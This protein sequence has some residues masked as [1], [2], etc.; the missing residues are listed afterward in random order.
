VGFRIDRAV[1]RIATSRARAS[2]VLTPHTS[3]S[4]DD[5]DAKEPPPVQVLFGRAQRL[6][7]ALLV[8][9]LETPRYVQ[10]GSKPRTTPSD[11]GECRSSV[12]T[13]SLNPTRRNLGRCIAQLARAQVGRES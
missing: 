5:S 2:S 12:Q 7:T 3:P 13:Q 4:H 6:P 11:E 9:A 1:R 10:L 8:F